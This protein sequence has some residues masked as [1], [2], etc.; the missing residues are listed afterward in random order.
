[1]LCGIFLVKAWTLT[2]AILSM[3]WFMYTSNQ[4]GLDPV[5]V[6]VLVVLAVTSLALAV[7]YL[8]NLHERGQKVLL[9]AIV[10]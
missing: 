10:P 5:F 4:Q 6:S 1:M 7:I 9:G 2:L 3:S 8:A